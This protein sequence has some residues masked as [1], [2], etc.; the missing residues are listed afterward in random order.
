MRRG[1]ISAF[2]IDLH[3]TDHRDHYLHGVFATNRWF[4]KTRT[5]LPACP[6]VIGK[7]NAF[8]HGQHCLEITVHTTGSFP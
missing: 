5:C 7:R 6:F 8:H 4:R 3:L 1:L 2:G